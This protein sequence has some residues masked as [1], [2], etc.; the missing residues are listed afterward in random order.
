MR[1]NKA[2]R[3]LSIDKKISEFNLPQSRPNLFVEINLSW[4]KNRDTGKTRPQM[5]QPFRLLR[6][7]SRSDLGRFKLQKPVI[8][9]LVLNFQNCE[10]KMF[11][12]ETRQKT[13][14]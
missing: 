10:L 4:K 12:A 9:F 1:K 14:V 13:K 3:R 2:G 6:P 7:A 5:F 11:I 8:L